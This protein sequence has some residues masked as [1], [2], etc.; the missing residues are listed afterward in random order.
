MSEPISEP[1]SELRSKRTV[2]VEF[3]NTGKDLIGMLRDAM[4]L[5]MA[6]LLIVW[7]Q[8]INDILVAAGFEEGS[9]AGMKWKAKLA[10][11][12]EVLLKSQ[13]TISDLRDQNE[14]LNN[15]LVEVKPQIAS[16]EVK[17]DIE[18]LEQINS[19]LNARSAQVQA[20]VDSTTSTNAM[21]IQ[22]IQVSTGKSATWGVVYG[23]HST[24]DSARYEVRMN[25]EK[26]ELKPS[27]IYYRQ[28]SY[29]SVAIA[30]DRVEAEKFLKMAKRYQ[31]EAYIVDLD[32]WCSGPTKE[33]GYVECST[34]EQKR[35]ELS[36]E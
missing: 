26:L 22:K 7:P 30:T 36:R 4:L 34:P 19:D 2:A 18:R 12:D 25:A 24:L 9:F 31:Q 5:V 3:I 6:V 21:L 32:T 29:R 14:K 27:T 1:V 35:Q 10:E 28:G 8:T 15:T 16:T 23:S 20:I 33:R 17:A 13:A 11:A